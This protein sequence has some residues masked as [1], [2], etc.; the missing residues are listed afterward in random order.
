L[1][2]VRSS[3]GR[4]GVSV[5]GTAKRLILEGTVPDTNA[6]VAA[7]QIA[8]AFAAEV[9]NLLQTPNP[10]LVNVEVSFVEISRNNARNLGIEYGTTTLLSE[11]ITGETV[12]VVP[13][14]NP[15]VLIT[16]PGGRSTTTA[17]DFN[18]GS[19][20]GG[21]NVAGTLRN[22]NP[23]RVRLNALYSNG[24]ARLLS[25]P[26]TTVLSGRTATFQVGGQVPIPAISTVG[27]NGSTTGIVFKDFG[28]L[29]DV[30]PNAGPDGAVTMRMRTEVSQPDFAIGV[31]PPGGGGPIPG[32]SRRSTVTEVTVRPNG[33][34]A[35]SGLIQNNV[36][37]AISKVPVLS[38]IPILGALFTSKRFQ[39][40]ETELVIFVTPT[41]LPNPLAPGTTAP[42]GVVAVG[43]TTNVGTVT[44]NPGIASFNSGAIFTPAGTG[45]G[46]TP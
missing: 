3:I 29:V 12:T 9:D 27:A 38:R 46:A 18:L 34:L 35:L 28:I 30:I 36:N 19:F 25:N 41:V 13:N 20:L 11:T 15:P 32:F 45:G 17:G 23:L 10:T 14:T 7:E 8:R 22:L 5:R 39:R 1:E 40:N 26:R 2:T 43:N 37:E 42:A 44:G 6:A 16:N 21:E 24:D 4:P 31:V 33:T